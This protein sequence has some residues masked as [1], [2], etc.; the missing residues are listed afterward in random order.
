MSLNQDEQ[1]KKLKEQPNIKDELDEKNGNKLLHYEV[2]KNNYDLILYI[3]EIGDDINYKNKDGETP[4]FL[5]IENKNN[6][7]INMLLEKGADPN[8]QNNLGET[9][10][11]I[12]TKLGD[13]KV[14]KLLILFNASVLI[15]N[16]KLQYPID[17]SLKYNNKKAYKILKETG[18]KECEII[19]KRT[20]SN[21]VDYSYKKNLMDNYIKKI[22][23]IEVRHD[24]SYINNRKK[25][26]STY[27]RPNAFRFLN[28]DNS[29]QIQQDTDMTSLTNIGNYNNSLLVNNNNDSSLKQRENI[30]LNTIESNH[31][32]TASKTERNYLHDIEGNI[33]LRSKIYNK[34]NYKQTES[35]IEY[36]K[37]NKLNYE[38]NQKDKGEFISKNLYV[39]KKIDNSSNSSFSILTG[40]IKKKI[41]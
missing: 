29:S 15:N 19:R 9:S 30:T 3:L 7:I 28:E 2:I 40:N 27:S 16:K 38:F 5:A 13:Y 25:S 24:Y 18:K 21:I 6:K 14:I 31:N 33:N 23:E 36:N 37:L 8:V 32:N 12:A 22:N 4:L 26:N 17:Y 20:M 39:K 35:G 41:I 34:L 11:H 10:I 1:K